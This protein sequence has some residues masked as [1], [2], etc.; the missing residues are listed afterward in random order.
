M[1]RTRMAV[2]AGLLAA[3][4]SGC[5]DGGGKQPKV[6]GNQDIQFKELPTPTVGGGKD[7]PAAGKTGAE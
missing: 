5:G 2:L 4:L 6:Q 7:A 1:R 3:A